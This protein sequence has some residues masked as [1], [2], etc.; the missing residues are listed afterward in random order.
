MG[1]SRRQLLHRLRRSASSSNA[2]EHGRPFINVR[3]YIR[4]FGEDPDVVTYALGITPTFAGKRDDRG[5][6]SN[7]IRSK[8]KLVE[9][10]WYVRSRLSEQAHMID[11]LRDIAAITVASTG[12][13]KLP[14]GARIEV[15][16]TI[17]W[18]Y[19]NWPYTVDASTMAEFARIGASVIYRRLVHKRHVGWL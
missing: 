10:Q 4:N 7:G 2:S 9:P 8:R 6:M 17:T 14:S 11:H 16:A 3:L 15:V 5:M 12:F 18:G 19:N 13:D 1:L